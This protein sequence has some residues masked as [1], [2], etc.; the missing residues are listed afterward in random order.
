MIRRPCYLLAVF[1][2]LVSGFS[3]TGIHAEEPRFS[4]DAYRAHFEFLAHDLLEGRAPGHRGG[5]LAALY[6]ATQFKAAGLE[7][8]SQEQGHLQ[9]VPLVRMSTDKQS[10][11]FTL[12][13][14]EYEVSLDPESDVIVISEL[15]GDDI[16]FSEELIYVGYGINAPEYDWDDYKGVDIEGKIA[17]MLGNDP[18]FEKTGF[19]SE[20]I[21]YYGM[22][23]YKEEIARLKGAKGL[24][25]LHSDETL[26]A[27]F[28]A[29]LNTLA[30]GL[31]SLEEKGASPLPLLAVISQPAIDR[32]LAPLELDFMKLKEEADSKDFRPRS[33]GLQAD[34]TFR[35]THERFF[36]PNVIGVLPGTSMADEAVIYMA[37]YDHL[38]IGPMVDGDEIYNG[39]RDNA[40]GTAALIC[41]AHAFASQPSKRTIIFL[42]TTAEE[43]GM[44]GTE[45]YAE[46]P[47]IPL[48]RTVVALNKDVC[49]VWGRRDG[50]K[51]FPV[52]YTDA[53]ETMR[54]IG[55]RQDLQLH[56]GGADIHG[57]AFRVDAFPLNARGIVAL[58]VW[59]D[60]DPLDTTEEE[61]DKAKETI[62]R[63]YHQPNDEIYPFFRFDGAV[64][65]LEILYAAG[66][67]FA[68]SE[69]APSLNPE[70]PFKPARRMKEL[71]KDLSH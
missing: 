29:L 71:L 63:W 9:A 43:T 51:A 15:E 33:L 60:G 21:S 66:R 62:G 46:H 17:V 32:A 31:V 5:D 45:Y 38:G 50:F 18:D 28:S 19:A 48:E 35:S 27:P 58:S 12:T 20:S 40:S 41:L 10:L 23:F 53:A 11:S 56:I 61:I 42:A 13:A 4:E 54:E 65:E 36:S 22:W 69:K 14:G 24:I 49:S 6:I 57:S 30:N 55:E 68:D 64:Q 3:T 67:Y 34:L 52:Q 37:H 1:L 16:R 47:I 25:L 26:L 8:I 59:L 39:A 2:Y 44:H 70:N 7:P